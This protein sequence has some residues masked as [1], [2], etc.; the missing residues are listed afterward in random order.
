MMHARVSFFAVAD[1]V[2]NVFDSQVFDHCAKVG[3]VV[4]VDCIDDYIPT[5]SPYM[6]CKHSKLDNVTQY[7]VTG[8]FCLREL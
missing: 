4:K 7:N 1:C 8:V 2:A 5:K 6:L 3:E